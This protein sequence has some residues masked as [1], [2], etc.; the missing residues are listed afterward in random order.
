MFSRVAPAHFVKYNSRN[1]MAIFSITNSY[2][3]VVDSGVKFIAVD[4]QLV[5]L[6]IEKE[7]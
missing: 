7:G 1:M 6:K 5:K 3:C 4:E 2:I